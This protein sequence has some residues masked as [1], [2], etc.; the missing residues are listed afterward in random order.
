[1]NYWTPTPKKHIIIESQIVMKIS[2]TYLVI[3]FEH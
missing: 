2:M 3:N 1:M